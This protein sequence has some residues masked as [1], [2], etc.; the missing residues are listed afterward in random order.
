MFEQEF[1]TLPFNKYNDLKNENAELKNKLH[2]L[3]NQISDH[4]LQNVSNNITIEI[5]QT[6][7]VNLEKENKFLNERILQLEKSNQELK[8]DNIE[9]KNTISKQNERISK[10]NERISKQNELISTQNERI[11]ELI[12]KQHIQKIIMA[13]QDLN[14]MFELEKH[15][16]DTKLFRLRNFRNNICHY[17]DDVNDTEFL[18]FKKM[19]NVINQLCDIDPNIKYKIEQSYGVNVV[20]KIIDYMKPVL[21]NYVCTI[22][23]IDEDD[24]NFILNQF[25]E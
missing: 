12:N 22:D 14:A 13:V 15:I 7:I 10:Q 11:D 25:W 23:K 4:F 1:I 19:E 9:H 17:F 2:M 6:Q 24:L 3:D 8:R 5:L 21:D 16:N 18:K 20:Q